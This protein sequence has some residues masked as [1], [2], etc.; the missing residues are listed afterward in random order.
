LVKA[1]TGETVSMEELGGTD[2]HTRK[3]GVADY[4]ADDDAQAIGIAREIVGNIGSPRSASR[5][6]DPPVAPL[7]DPADIYGIVSADGRKPYDVRQVM[8]RRWSVLSGR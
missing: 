3:S 8:A 1:A 4:A 6:P 2:V 7:Y 5:E